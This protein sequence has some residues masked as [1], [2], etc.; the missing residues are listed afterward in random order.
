VN[1]TRVAW[2]WR[3][4]DFHLSLQEHN[5]VSLQQKSSRPIMDG[6]PKEDKDKNEGF[7]MTPFHY[8]ECKHCK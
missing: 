1:R 8:E 5:M 3:P 4:A 7:I 2:F 6:L